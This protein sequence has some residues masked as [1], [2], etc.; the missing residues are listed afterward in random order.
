MNKVYLFFVLCFLMMVTDTFS[1]QAQNLL[2]GWDD[3]SGTPYDA[4]WQVDP[5]VSVTW[6]TLTGNG[7]RYRINV[8]SPASNG[9][10]PM[11]YIMLTDTKFAYPVTLTAGKFYELSGKAWRRNGGDGSS[12]TFNFYLADGFSATTLPASTVSR[13]LSGNNAVS[14]FSGLRL[15]APE[16]FTNGYFLWDVHIN[17]GS[18]NDAGVWLLNLTELGDAIAVTFDVDGG[19]TIAAQY[20]LEGESYTIN[21]PVDP[22]KDGYIFDGWY[23]DNTYQ[24]TF[25]FTTPVSANTTIFAKWNNIK[26]ELETLITTATG[27]LSGGTTT[28][29][30][31]LNGEIANA[32]AVVQNTGATVNE[33]TAAFNTLTAAIATYQNASLSGIMV[34]GATIA[35]FSATVYNYTYNLA[36][37][38]STP[39]VVAA[40]VMAT[41]VS[42]VGITQVE[43]FPG[44]ATIVVT[45]GDNS[46]E[47]YTVDF[48]F[49]YMSGWDGNGIGTT[50]DIPD[51]FGW[52]CSSS[53]VTWS[54]ADNST[55]TYAYRYRD[56]LGVG[57][58]ITHPAN[59]NVFSFPVQ[60]NTGK[61][62]RFTC[63]NANMNRTV[64]TTFGINTSNDATG[65][66]IG[67]QTKTSPQWSA[68]TV[69]DF[70]FAVIESGTYYMVWQ[71][72]SGTDRNFA[73][74][75]LVTETGDAAS[76]T[77]N[78]DGGSAIA[79]QYFEKDKPYTVIEPEEPTKDGYDFAGWYTS[80]DYETPFN[81]NTPIYDNTVIY[82]RFV[83]EG[84]QPIV[85]T[86]IVDDIVNYQVAK[87]MNITVS[88]KSELHLSSG[89][90][91]LINSTINLTSEDSW[92]YFDAIKPST[93]VSDWIEYVKING[94]DFDPN[95]DRIAI[96]GD[97]TVVIP[98]GKAYFQNALTVYK[99]V[100]FTGESASYGI[101]TYYKELGEFDNNIQ[102]FKLKKGFSATL[103]NNPDGTGFSRVF[104]ASDDD[105]EV[106]EMPEGMEG[107]VSFIRVFKW[108]WTGKK[109]W[110]GG[111]SNQLNVSINYDWDAA[112]NTENIDTE[113]VPMR[114]NL[115][116][117]SF[118]VINSRNNVSH[119][120]GYNEPER[121]DQ[122]NMPVES[123]IEQWPEFF[124]SGLRLGSPAPSAM[125]QAWLTNFIN[126]CDSLNY[127]V[128]F[129][130]T[131]TYNYQNT[132][133]WEWNIDLTARGGR[134][135]SLVEQKRP[136]WVTEWN[137]GANW[138]S[139]SWPTAT[140]AQRDADLNV[141]LDADGNE[142]TV[143]KPLS[144]ENAEQSKA[145]IEGL[146]PF[147]DTQDLLEHHFLY[148]WV[149]DARSMELNGRLT[150]AGKSFAAH[151]SQVGF[152]KANEY[153]HKWK[154]A[155]PWINSE[156]SDDYGHFDL[157][158]YDHN[159]ETGK[160]YVLERKL[161]GEANF[162][163][164]A[165]ITA[166]DDYTYGG[167]VSY[168]DDIVGKSA[169][170]RV[171]A[172]S[173]K[174]TESLYSRTISLVLD[175]DISAPT[176]LQGEAVSSTIINLSWT[177]VDN[178]RSYN[179]K[180]SSDSNGPYETIGSFLAE[181][182]FRDET[183]AVNTTYYYKVSALNNRGET[184]DSNPI[185]V[186]TRAITMPDAVSGLFISAGDM[187][188]TLTWDYQYDVLFRVYRSD[189]EDGTYSIVADNIDGTYFLDKGLINGKTYYYKV[190][191]FN[192]EGENI[193]NT[194][195]NVT[196][197]EGQY[198]YFNFDENEGSIAYDLWG[199]YHGTLNNDAA[200]TSGQTNTAVSF[201]AADQ[202]FIQ[203]RDGLTDELNDFTISLW[204]NYTS[205]GSRIFDFGES[206]DVFMML[207]PELRYKITCPEG[208]FDVTAAGNTLPVGQWSYLT[209]TQEGNT[210]KM[211]MNG[212]EILS[213]NGA[214]VK[215]SDMGVNTKNYLVKS[216]W[217]SDRYS[218]CLLDEFRI[219]NRALSAEEI[220]ALMNESLYSVELNES[221]LTLS[222]G[223]THQLSI[224]SVFPDNA[225]AST[226]S[227]S[228][229][230]AGIAGVIDGLVTAVSPGTTGI[231]LINASSEILATCLITVNVPEVASAEL[232]ENTLTL[233]VGD[234][235]RLSIKSVFPGNADAS[236][237]SWSS[238]N[239][240]IARVIDGLVTAVSPGTTGINLINA[241]SEIL[242]TC[243][244]TVNVPVGTAVIGNSKT[245]AFIKK[246]VLYIENPHNETI[247]VYNIMG[248]LL[249][250]KKK[251]AGSDKI[252]LTT[253]DKVL[254]VKGSTGWTAK[255]VQ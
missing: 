43:T 117:Q 146:L 191:A 130:V 179:V 66:M 218:T 103:A 196:S 253:T 246:H 106:S 254:I 190:S 22:T 92:L 16:G 172:I 51:A 44:I 14:T 174:D 213:D 133:W 31:Y 241:S 104:I 61:V 93:V 71:T 187:Q 113:Y 162:S 238:N 89:S 11:L 193:G 120:L 86:S 168:T 164:L 7:N 185:E 91:P 42:T 157:S 131:H 38:A 189:G 52:A 240:G 248:Q 201:T 70:I 155:P 245:I 85:N 203:L 127:R 40:T 41:N 150:P 8:G 45:A 98:N 39:A 67:S 111:P 145:K 4:G 229:N 88:G 47:T 235:H 95:A 24:T 200:Y 137:N 58:V 239:V 144:P 208:T 99:G 252:T 128:D 126:I 220:N 217:G 72:T 242:A 73:W 136:V 79:D 48:R 29:Q 171:K 80:N 156:L 216:R 219:Y 202:S 1:L 55:D 223:D 184:A 210:F 82:A 227:W 60:L 15:V 199:G 209:L 255:L 178:A 108:E 76:V 3:T 84:D 2:D 148:N 37:D 163:V 105:I 142:I 87:Y 181:A 247:E 244:V 231:N 81:F 204:V 33:A 65:T 78:T 96:Y 115:G 28:G 161:D 195:L 53:S 138:T 134:D 192:T 54:D 132:G 69:F 18:W 215:P 141:I 170:Y 176:G 114:H 75:F 143:N 116:W 182:I 23:T 222:I 112:A 169:E 13:T 77:F 198:A 90:I 188:A 107:F 118:D 183:L 12:A 207:S 124:K 83:S 59:D 122:A 180:R 110:A 34:N 6:G 32:Q 166:V 36:P 9:T 160:C 139:E 5:G 19:N 249:I 26:A 123:A 10:D 232:S 135:A 205:K 50:T 63:N 186:T 211:Y 21:K 159:G 30:T 237:L 154:I 121:S 173:Y 27:L 214:I 147:F 109:G 68:T 17:G 225:D 197:V 224:K 20:F 140:G 35:G 251:Q 49:N 234:T 101:N 57:R 158:W 74:N 56:N 228:S 151:K 102:S 226:L 236:T 94:V 100:N 221:A 165:T 206:T 129:M 64:S 177:P 119:L 230:N 46:T 167:Q 125:P 25:D 175:S 243:R 250:K 233:L 149:Q 62:Y 97:G 212:E 153:I 152:K 194:I